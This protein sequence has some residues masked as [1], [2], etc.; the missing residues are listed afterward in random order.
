M[1]YIHAL[2]QPIVWWK[3]VVWVTSAEAQDLTGYF[4]MQVG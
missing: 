3:T 4:E 2:I 1:L